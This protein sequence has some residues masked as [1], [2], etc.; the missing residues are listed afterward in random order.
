MTNV[1]VIGIQQL[2]RLSFFCGQLIGSQSQFSAPLRLPPVPHFMDTSVLVTI[3][4]AYA[5]HTLSS[6]YTT[7][8][9]TS[10]V[11][12]NSILH[13]SPVCMPYSWLQQQQCKPTIILTITVQYWCRFYSTEACITDTLIT[14]ANKIKVLFCNCKTMGG[15]YIFEVC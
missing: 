14:Q 5:L 3:T 4:K 11:S 15:L 13:V 8:T 10:F 7:T 12:Q 2:K 1:H 9:N 6:L